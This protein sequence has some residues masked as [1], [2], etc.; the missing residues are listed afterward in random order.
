MKKINTIIGCIVAGFILLLFVLNTCFLNKDFNMSGKEYKV[1]VNRIKKEILNFEE[2]YKRAPYHI[3]ELLEYAKR[4][5]FPEIV[6]VTPLKI[7]ES[8]MEEL[9]KFF[10]SENEYILISTKEYCY[11][12]TYIQGKNLPANIVMIVNGVLL[13]CMIFIIGILLFVCQNILKPFHKFS[14][15]PYE[16]SKGKLT[17][18]LKERKERFFGRFLWGMDLLRENLEENKKKELELVKEKK[19]L[20]LSLSHDIK[21]QLSAIKLYS[22]ALSKNLYKKEEKKLEIAEKI[23]LK[24]D[25]IEQ[26]ISEIIHASN[27]DFLQFE[28]KNTEFYLAD[29]IE[30]I[31]EYYKEKMELNQI[32]FTISEYS[33]VFLYGDVERVIE[34]MQNVIEN[35]IKYGDGKWIAMEF[36]RDEEAC[37]ISIENS[38]CELEEK[39]VVHLFDSFFRGS[40]VSNK[41]GSGLGLYICRQLMHQMDGEIVAV[42]EKGNEQEKIMKMTLTLRMAT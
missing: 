12:I 28:V 5:E 22:Q 25:E 19:M 20:L 31:R 32:Q 1:S 29:A 40:N 41:S 11:K 30:K 21:T 14:M 36:C 2:E 15:L 17:I 7:K 3:K 18:P 38:G 13:F 34:T 39:E 24:V 16:L 9:E 4:E 27:E 42:I 10:E 23:S 33:N 26:F 35:A 6:E 37:T 8:E